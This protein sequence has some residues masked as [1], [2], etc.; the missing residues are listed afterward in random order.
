MAETPN[1]PDSDASSDSSDFRR[2]S[3]TERL[4]NPRPDGSTTPAETSAS[5]AGPSEHE[6]LERAHLAQ[7]AQN[8]L[9]TLAS[10]SSPTSA[11]ITAA[12]KEARRFVRVRYFAFL[13]LLVIVGLT[14]IVATITLAVS[15]L[16]EGTW[17]EKVGS[18][19][20]AGGALVVL[21]LMQYRPAR[22]YS[23]ASVELTQLEAL[24]TQLEST[25]RL[26]DEFLARREHE[27]TAADL[28]SAV[29]SMTSTTREMV[30]LHSDL[31][32]NRRARAASPVALPTPTF[33]DPRRY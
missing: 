20:V 2:L 16:D 32:Q 19:A 1:R 25:Y 26:W 28:A 13:A 27:L 23:T 24:R 6:R 29:L 18:A 8:E 14:L 5:A 10:F 33:P 15:L 31:V 4:M 12:L 22:T 30:S 11:S 21:I 7:A 17:Q 3:L 9:R